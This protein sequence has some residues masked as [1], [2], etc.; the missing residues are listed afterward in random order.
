MATRTNDAAPELVLPRDQFSERLRELSG[1]PGAVHSASR[2]DRTDF[3]GRHESW[4]LDTFR[5]DGGDE[6][7]LLQRI[8]ASGTPVRIVLPEGVTAALARH[9]DRGVTASRRRGARAA[10]ATKRAAGVAIGNPEALRKARRR[11]RKAAK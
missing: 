1:N 2:V 6:V 10:V 7:V 9:R 4:I 3:Y 11:T 8:D 5:L